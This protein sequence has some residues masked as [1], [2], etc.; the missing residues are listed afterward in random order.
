MDQRIADRLSPYREFSRVEWAA[1]RADTPMTLAAEEVMRLRS[2]HDRLDI[3]EIED[4]YLAAAAALALCRRDPA[5]VPGT[6]TL[7]RHRGCQDALRDRRAGS[8]AVGN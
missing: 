1:L 3:A 8:V 7:P 5:T 4:I 2:V 6:T